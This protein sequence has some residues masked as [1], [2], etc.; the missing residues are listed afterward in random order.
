MADEQNKTRRS[1]RTP[2]Q[3]A[4]AIDAK[5]AKLQEEKEKI[6]EPVRKRELLE[7]ASATMSLEEIAEKLGI[8]L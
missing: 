3:K 1:R 7:K 2:E 5:I 6:L 4:A 8:E